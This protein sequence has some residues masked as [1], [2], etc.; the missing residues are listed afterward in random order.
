MLLSVYGLLPERDTPEGA[1]RVTKLCVQTCPL[2]VPY[3][4]IYEFSFYALYSINC[5]IIV[6]RR[7]GF[8]VK[9]NES[10]EKSFS[11]LSSAMK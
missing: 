2:L 1:N 10:D 7:S 11:P 3:L 8:L 9:S 5:I 4:F 6:V